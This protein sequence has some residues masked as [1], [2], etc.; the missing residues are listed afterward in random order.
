MIVYI[1]TAMTKK[2]THLVDDLDIEK[3]SK[4]QKLYEKKLQPFY[5]EKEICEMC[6]VAA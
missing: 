3:M 6:G 5:N 1:E 4:L 2:Y